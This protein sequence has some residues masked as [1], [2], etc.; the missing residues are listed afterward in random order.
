M[1]LNFTQLG[2]DRRP[3]LDSLRMAAAAG[4][5]EIS[6]LS[7]PDGPVFR[8]GSTPPASFI[9]VFNSDWVALKAALEQQSLHCLHIHAG[10]LDVANDGAAAT[11][12][13]TLSERAIACHNFGAEVVSFG[14]GPQLPIG[15]PWEEKVGYL[16]RAVASFQSIAARIDGLPIRMGVDIHFRAPVETVRDAE[17]VL[18]QSGQSQ[19]GLCVNTGHLTTSGEPGWELVERFPEAVALVAYKDHVLGSG[20]HSLRL[21]AADTPLEKY[22]AAV[23]D[24]DREI[25]QVVSIEHEPWDEKQLAAQESREYLESLVS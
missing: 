23:Q 11:S 9:D 7:S 25:Y 16:D 4:Y 22:V 12:A 24:A 5:R 3:F 8:S 6:L 10:G 20:V 14:I 18:E 19:V 15:L 2:D 1:I 17:Y 21:G 13:A